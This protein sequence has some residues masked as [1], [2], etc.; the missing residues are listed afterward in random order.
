MTLAVAGGAALNQLWGVYA[1]KAESDAKWDAT[2]A[3]K[4]LLK[5]CTPIQRAFISNALASAVGYALL[6][7]G[8]N[9]NI[10][11]KKR[12]AKDSLLPMTVPQA[13]ERDPSPT[14]DLTLLLLVRAMDALVQNVVFH[15]SGSAHVKAELERTGS[16][17]WVGD[18]LTERLIRE[19]EKAT[20]LERRRLTT[21]IDALVF[22]ACSARIMWCFFYAPHRLPGAYVHW[23]SKLANVDQRLLDALK[24]LG[25][26]EW[27]YLRGT[28]Q[29]ILTSYASDLGLPASWGDPHILPAFGGPT[30]NRVWNKIGVKGR[31]GIGGLPCELV[32]GDV[33]VGDS[34]HGNA[35][36]RLVHAF[37]AAVAMYIPVHFAPILLTRP[38]TLLRPQHVLRAIL[39]AMRSSL[40]LSSFVSLFFY[41]V[42]FTRTL[43]LSRALPFISFDYWDGPYGDILMGCLMCGSSIWIEQGKRRGEMALYVL[44]RAL[45]ASLPHRWLRKGGRSVALTEGATFILSMA[46][47]LTAGVHHPDSLRGLSRWA[48]AFMLNGPYAGFWKRRREVNTSP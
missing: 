18:D 5:R 38:K 17:D 33:G 34:C 8:R 36:V 30:A 20:A 16:R 46:G 40:F 23:I 21:R 45:R 48:L 3:L 47:L 26:G 37:A 7:S 12:R 28:D 42:C 6:R 15:R 39:G 22:W 14:L 9:R 1:S 44:P 2:G 41:S 25:T 4:T 13:Q 43:V 27:S 32:H 29:N 19:K 10:N 24:L 31:S 35:A 11:L